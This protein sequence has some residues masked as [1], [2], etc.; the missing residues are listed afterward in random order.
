MNIAPYRKLEAPDDGPRILSILYRIDFKASRWHR[1]AERKAS[2]GTVVRNAP[3]G[4][5]V[6]LDEALKNYN[7]ASS[8]RVGV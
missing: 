8:I 5:E 7:V 4:D 1:I 3:T 2:R 6:N